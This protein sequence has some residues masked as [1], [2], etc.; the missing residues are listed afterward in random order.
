MGLALQLWRRR[1]KYSS[2]SP[3]TLRVASVSSGAGVDVLNQSQNISLASL[4]LM[5][6]GPL[7]FRGPHYTLITPLSVLR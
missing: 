7:F 1:G 4:F 3:Q 6:L 2:S 5:H